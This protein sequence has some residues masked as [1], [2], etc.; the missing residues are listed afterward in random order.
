MRSVAQPLARLAQL[1]IGSLRVPRRRVQV[2]V[3]ENLG[4][5][6][7]ILQSGSKQIYIYNDMKITF[8]KGKVSDVQ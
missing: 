7:Q 1:L 6:N 4:Q 3:P 5:P 2:L 8:N